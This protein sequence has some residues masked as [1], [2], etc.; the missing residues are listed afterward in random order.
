MARF[1]VDVLNN[2]LIRAV[3]LVINLLL[4]GIVVVIASIPLITIVPAW[5]AAFGVMRQWSRLGDSSVLRPFVNHLRTYWPVMLLDVPVLVVAVATWLNLRL[6]PSLQPVVLRMPTL[7]ISVVICL[8]IATV[9]VLT[10]PVLVHYDVT[11]RGAARLAAALALRHVWVGVGT[12]LVLLA[13]ATLTLL[14]PLVGVLVVGPAIYAIHA[15]C[16]RAFRADE[17]L[18]SE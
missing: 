9:V 1:R 6:V 15:M 10:L 16:T 17:A 13:C 4:V 3:E 8:A 7:I 12:A 11:L 2:R 14:V 18:A 5:T